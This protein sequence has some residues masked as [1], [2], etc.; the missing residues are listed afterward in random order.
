MAVSQ[1]S[2]YGGKLVGQASLRACWSS[3][4]T[5]LA[6]S[7]PA[8]LVPS[9]RAVSPTTKPGPPVSPGVPASD[10]AN[11]P[12]QLGLPLESLGG[13]PNAVPDNP[14][15][16][17]VT[18]TTSRMRRLIVI[19]LWLSL[20]REVC[21]KAYLVIY[22]S[23][24]SVTQQPHRGCQTLRFQESSTHGANPPRDF[25]WANNVKRQRYRAW[26]LRSADAAWGGSGSEK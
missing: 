19:L 10:L 6:V 12:K 9:V 22:N 13:S 25:A 4:T 8:P 14:T 2:P 17:T 23:L 20:P 24:L 5:P 11:A 18:T 15:S 3:W 7:P 1:S 16:I 21:F 26:A